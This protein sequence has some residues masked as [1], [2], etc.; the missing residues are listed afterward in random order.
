[1]PVF[2][3]GSASVNIVPDFTGGKQAIEAWF[4]RQGDYKVKVSADLDRTSMPAIQAQVAAYKPTLNIDVDK[5]YLGKSLA[6]AANGLTGLSTLASSV[7]A[8][9]SPAMFAGAIGGLT[10]IAS[11]AAGAGAAL[12]FVPAAV[13][14]VAAP[15]ATLTIGMQ[16][17]GDAFKAFADGDAAK[18][19]EALANLSPAARDFAVQVHDLAPAFKDLR[20]DVQDQLFRGLGD[21]MTE[22]GGNYLPVVRTALAGMA[23]DFNLA[24]AS[25][26]DFLNQSNSIASV[27]IILGNVRQAV[28]NVLAGLAPLGTAFLY[29][30]DV[31]SAFLPGMTA[32]FRGL[33]TEFAAFIAQA[34]QSGQLAAFM[35]AGIDTLKALGALV[36]QVG[37]TLIAVFQAANAAGATLIQSLTELFNGLNRIVSLPLGQAALATFFQGIATAVQALL[38]GVLAVAGVIINNLLPAFGGLLASLGPI[39]GQLLVQFAGLLAALTPII[40]TVAAAVV[41]LFNAST[42]LIPVFTQIIQAILPPLANLLLQLAPIIGQVAQIIG[43]ALLSAVQ[44]IAPVLPTLAT[45]FIQILQALVPLLPV[46][47]NLALQLLPPLLQVVVALAPFLVALAQR[48]AELAAAAAGPL[49]AALSGIASVM[50][51]VLVPVIGFLTDHI[52]LVIV[53]LGAWAI[54][55]GIVATANALAL[56]GG[57]DGMIVKVALWIGQLGIVTAATT[58]WGVVTTAA[59]AAFAFLTSPIGLVVLAVAALAAGIIYAYT[60][61]ETFRAIVLGAWEAIRAAAVAIFDNYLVPLWATLV[62]A[63]DAFAA[64]VSAAWTAIIQPVWAALQAAAGALSAFLAGAW[65]LAQQAWD[66]LGQGISLVWT[67]VIMPVWAA[68]Q[69]AAGALGAFLAGAWALIQAGWDALG[70]GIAAVWNGVIMPVWNA[71]DLAGRVLVAVITTIVIAPILI[72]WELLG[73]LIQGIWTS[74][75]QPTWVALQAL[76]GVMADYLQLL[77]NNLKAAWQS[78]A[79]LWT[80]VFNTVIA[81]MWATLQGAMQALGDFLQLTWNNLKAAWQ[82]LG[83]LWTLVYNTLILPMWQ[84]LQAAMTALGDFL[85]MIWEQLKQRW[86]DLGNLW[87]IVYNTVI[88]PMWNTLHGAMQVLADFLS[89]IWEQLKQRWTDLGNLWTIVYNTVIQPMWNA[90]QGAA[91]VLRD[92]LGVVWNAMQA[93]WDAMGRGLRAVYDTVIVPMFDAVKTAVDAVRA[94]FQVAVDAIGTLWAAIKEKVAEPI[95]FLVNTVYTQ[96]IKKAWDTVADVVGIPKAP[97]VTLNFADGGEIPGLANGG[98]IPGMW[99]GPR[100]DN[101]LGVVDNKQPVK[102]NPREWIQPVSSVDQY[103]KPFMTAVQTGAFPTELARNWATYAFGGS[104]EGYATG[105]QIGAKALEILPGGVI[106]STI[107]A[108]DPGYHGKNQAADISGGPGYVSSGNQYLADLEVAWA[109]RYGANT[110]QLIHDGKFNRTADL[111]NGQPHTYN[112]A[113]QAEHTNHV[114]IAYT[115]DLGKLAPGVVAPDGVTIPVNWEDILASLMGQVAS[116]FS[117]PAKAAVKSLSSTVLGDPPPRW[118]EIPPAWG[119]TVIDKAVEYMKGKATEK[120]KAEAAATNAAA[121]TAGTTPAPAVSGPIKSQVSQVFAS[122][123]WGSGPQWEAADWII[124]KESGWNPTAQNPVSTASGLFQF[125]DGTWAAYRPAGSTAPKARLAPVNE[126][127]MAGMAYMGGR[128]G[129]PIKAKAYWVAHGN[130]AD[131]GEVLVRDTGGPL[132]PGMHTVYNGTRKMETVVNAAQRDE[133]IRHLSA[134]PGRAAGATGAEGPM[135]V[136][137]YIGDKEITD[138]IDVRVEH[139]NDNA[140]R[141]IRSGAMSS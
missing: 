3:G 18:V 97:T 130:Y 87:T 88:V 50:S 111:L 12:A 42:P 31:G 129:D 24:G 126:Q 137:V 102:L 43:Q 84:N 32:G 117:G 45:A 11:S 86:T 71:I 116:L 54:A 63:W 104:I 121:A 22:L 16:G 122:R 49:G 134:L 26:L 128:Y 46:I 106:T 82:A 23:G 57:I 103:G 17:M 5:A 39:V 76:G 10:A 6:E 64:G 70:A 40:P 48:F 105:A 139:H 8:V 110:T 89:L 38:P 19:E 28:A 79:D 120:A 138:M 73:T 53:A 92:A 36:V 7:S 15:V 119:N 65:S 90:L 9:L 62:G 99:R 34:A 30:A 109:E 4:A 67:G 135:T 41:A 66:L 60:H 123:G 93:A 98:P 29:I 131:G 74:L 1:M 58:L 136:H 108:G 61:S 77:W 101:V 51:A 91:G 118:R 133:L 107:R 85:T 94:A 20:L 44:Q 125:I 2:T 112:A 80:I 72:A 114:H 14:A 25:V 100:A 33:T 47:L 115:G 59:A 13:V 95:R 69:A 35:Q 96:G 75:I 81:P 78:L 113:T 27:E 140:G 83:D 55:T 37:A 56:A 141:H 21:R 68:L 124:N 52:N 127:A 132:P